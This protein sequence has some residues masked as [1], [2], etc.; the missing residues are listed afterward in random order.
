MVRG[1]GLRVT[2]VVLTSHKKQQFE[3]IFPIQIAN[4][5]VQWLKVLVFCVGSG[6]ARATSQFPL[7][8]KKD[9]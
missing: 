8:T 4:C 3:G 9:Y 5:K 6:R 1:I 2:L 7:A